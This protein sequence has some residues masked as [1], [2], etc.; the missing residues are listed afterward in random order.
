[1]MIG[2]VVS[3]QIFLAA[4]V[5]SQAKAATPASSS[6]QMTFSTP[7][8]AVEALIK[9]AGDYDVPAL[10][11]I[12]GPAGKDF[13]TS[14]DPV[15]DKNNSIAFA[16]RAR[17]KNSIQTDPHNPNRDT[18]V[19][20]D[21]GWPFPVPLVRKNGQWH[22]DS[23]AGRSEILYRRIGA[24]ELDAIQVCRGYVEAQRD[25]AADIHDGSKVNQ[26]AQKVIS[27][28]GKQDGLYWKKADGT[29][30]GPISEP[31]AKAIAEGY[32]FDKPTAFHGY[33]FKILK[34]QGPAA[35]LGKINYVIQG[36][37]IGGFALVAVPTNYRVTGVKTF[38][39]GPEGIVYEKDLGPDSLKI[40]KQMEL[41]NPDKTWHPTE[42]GWPSS[43]GED[44]AA[45]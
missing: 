18:L 12:F 10:T 2:L 42:D 4:A 20:G 13:I 17:A 36:A 9:A 33:Y 35:P 23:K 25:Y 32:K 3:A 15:R 27:T 45:K 38:I 28:P 37:M 30:G 29:P 40:A 39:V 24:N 7:Q 31:V 5:Q 16:G 11:K 43:D 41:Y 19:V 21:D 26:Y 8:T 6:D 1:L 14:G 44:I 34:G 22:F